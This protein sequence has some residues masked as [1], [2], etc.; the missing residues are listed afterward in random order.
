MSRLAAL[1]PDRLFTAAI[2]RTYRRFEPELARL[3]EFC[4]DHGTAVDVGAWYGPWSRALARRVSRV[5]ALEP[6]PR[7]A[8]VLAATVPHN[9][10]VIRAAITDRPGSAELWV[11]RTG[12]GTEG[13]ASLRP[14]TAAAS[15]VQVATTTIDDL[16][17]TDVTMIKLDVEGAE[18]AALRGARST[19]ASCRPALLI[20]LE[21]RHGPVD[22][23]LAF[24][25]D[26]GY[27]GE[28]LLAGQWVSLFMFD[29]AGHQRAV[30]PHIRGYLPTI[31][32]GGPRYI[33]NVLFRAR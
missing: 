4:P 29:L 1:V 22:N 27:T 5:V 32:R 2:A 33:N 28:I 21:Y 20:E 6:N 16:N 7:V 19:L 13:T 3:T 10:Q 15:S 26:M 8:A 24:L 23:V 30:A 31:L 25:A 12:R 17:L 14:G 18:L 9:V 11:P